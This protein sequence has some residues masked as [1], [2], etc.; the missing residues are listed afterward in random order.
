M[1]RSASRGRA[2]HGRVAARIRELHR[3]HAEAAEGF[4][5]AG[6]AAV[7]ARTA[8]TFAAALR[9]RRTLLFFGNGGS[10]ADAQHLAA[11][12]VN[13][14][15]RDRPALAALALTTDSSV[16]TSIG[17]DDDFARIFARQVEAL[18]R[19]GDVAVGISTSGRSA[20]VLEGLRAARD[21]DLVTVGF[22]GRDGGGMADLCRH[23]VSVPARETARIQE[24]HILAGH[25]LCQLVDEALFPDT[26]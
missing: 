11:E 1:A 6:G 17:N 13:R 7:L 21:R 23:L 25:I 18:G 3:A 19:P 8:D 12:F 5:A 9:A 4:F 14:F 15:A 26:R 2:G 24:V 16:L 10:A 22:T 20:N